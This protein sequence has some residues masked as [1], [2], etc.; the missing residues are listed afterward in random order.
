MMSLPPRS[1]AMSDSRGPKAATVEDYVSDEDDR[2]L[3]AAKSANSKARRKPAVHVAALAPEDAASDSGYSSHAAATV[4]SSDSQGATSLATSSTAAQSG[5]SAARPLRRPPLP[6]SRTT[7]TQPHIHSRSGGISGAEARRMSRVPSKEHCACAE[8][9]SIK[10]TFAAPPD[11]PLDTKYSSVEG[12]PRYDDP[13]ARSSNRPRSKE[14]PATQVPR[15]RMLKLNTGPSARPVS[16]HEGMS[17]SLPSATR[18]PDPAMDPV[19]QVPMSFAANIPLTPT[20]YAPHPPS[21]HPPSSPLLPPGQQWGMP[22]QYVESRPP[23]QRWVTEQYAA[24]PVSTYAVP[25]SEYHG[26]PP[27]AAPMLT[28]RPSNRE[29][30]SLRVRSREEED[31]YRMPPPPPPPVPVPVARPSS[32]PAV[33]H[34]SS[35]SSGKEYSRSR[36]MPRPEEVDAAMVRAM[37]RAEARQQQQE[38]RVSRRPSLH[39]A[40]S[41]R[42]PSGYA[43]ES[44]K[45]QLQEYRRRRA[46]YYGYE[47]NQEY[48]RAMRRYQEADSDVNAAALDLEALD[49]RGEHSRTGSDSGS[50]GR[51][52]GSREGSDVKARPGSGVAVSV[53]ESDDSFTM[54][55]TSNTPVK[56]DF[57]GGFEGR[58]VSLKPGQPGEQAELS[59][60]SSRKGYIDNSGMQLEYART[61]RLR[62]IEERR[63][64]KDPRSAPHSRRP[65]RASSR[66]PPMF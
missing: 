39:T 47:G 64:S 25:M 19:Y 57:T 49:M 11:A 33:R 29:A 54:R 23:P 45:A 37:E 52:G 58:T 21:G 53:P 4:A 44:A 51:P 6:S 16:Y 41:E 2:A 66:R 26:G 18:I 28:R 38:A 15:P 3:D 46:T 20:Y 60:G 55:F 59:I 65:S 27:P 14:M 12:A 17:Y 43:D 36:S 1:G 62:E 7:S 42:R 35:T 31:Y 5:S 61:G 22:M 9:I 8:C 50:Q 10:R 24:R 13:S 63:S 48:E 40:E 56:L 32:R 34:R 30:P